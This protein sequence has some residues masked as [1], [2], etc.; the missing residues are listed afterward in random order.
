MKYLPLLLLGFLSMN[1]AASPIKWTS[2]DSCPNFDA[3]VCGSFYF[4]ADTGAFSFID[5]IFDGVFYGEFSNSSGGDQYHLNMINPVPPV[6]YVTLRLSGFDLAVPV[7]QR[8]DWV[9]DYRSIIHF[10]GSSQL[11]PSFEPPPTPAPAPGTLFLCG[12]ALAVMRLARR[13]RSL[14]MLK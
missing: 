5:L 8:F 2:V 14:T 12:M 7:Q 9:Y 10:E 1:I 4:D 11:R 3:V 6:H 13:H